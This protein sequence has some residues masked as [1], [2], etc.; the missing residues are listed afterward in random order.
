MLDILL[1]RK[2]LDSVIARLQTRKN[3]QQFLNVEAFK[4]L[5][6]ERK[7]IQ[8]R[9]EE[10]Q[11]KR[12]QLSKQIGMLMGKG[13]KDAAEA[14]K[15]D[16]AAMKTELEQSATR[17]DALQ[18][19]LQ[20]MLVAVPNL[21][22]ESVPVGEDESA[23]V[24]VRRWGTPRS[25]D[26]E[27]KDHV[28]VGTP[29][30]LDFEAG[31]KLTGSRF[32]VM[33][34]PIARLHRALAQFMIDLQ[35]EQHGYTECYVPYIVNSDSLKGTGQLPKFEGDLF[36][37]NKG[38]QDAEPVPDTAALYLI[39]TS[40]VPL[41]NLV[42]DEV[43]SEDQLPI[44]LTAHSPCFRSEAGSAGRDTR[45]LIRQHQFDKVEMVQV[46]HPDKSYEALEEMTRHA[47]DV[48]QRLG[49]P[50]RVLALSTGDMGFGAAKTYDLEV[51]LP[52]QNTYR[53]ISSVSNCEAFQARRMQARFKNAQGRNE[54]VHTL[55]GSG[56]A[57]GRTLVAVLENYQNADGS[58]TVPEAL[59]PYLGGVAVLKV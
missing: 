11:A 22:H 33:K 27:I 7:T 36:A 8:T 9:T 55:N 49:L 17:L 30:G 58:V 1:L 14:A 15:A 23:N 59:Q 52:A 19:E 47:E 31:V 25:F 42:R 29:L 26:F 54:L 32:T 43:L 10:L 41:T 21:P 45:G 44:K 39:P 3:P 46:V 16:V 6:A 57:V 56:L 20:A 50:Y 4:A 51:W 38:G 37:A 40:E 18:A 35:T 2:D 12:N 5:E 28:D 53:E 24:E 48:L 34:G 13:E